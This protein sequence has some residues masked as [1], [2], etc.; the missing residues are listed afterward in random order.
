MVLGMYL[1]LEVCTVRHLSKEVRYDRYLL[2]YLAHRLK[3][4][5]YIPLFRV[6]TK[7]EGILG[8]SYFIKYQA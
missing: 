4:D 2:I 1:S 5:F 7:P 6:N 3:V 8:L